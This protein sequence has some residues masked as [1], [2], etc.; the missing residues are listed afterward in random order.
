MTLGEKYINIYD[1]DLVFSTLKFWCSIYMIFPSRPF[2][3]VEMLPSDFSIGSDFG[4]AF[5]SGTTGLLKVLS[6]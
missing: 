3:I 1:L 4:A 6:K 2:N 5:F